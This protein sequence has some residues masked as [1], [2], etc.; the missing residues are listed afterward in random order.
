M[1]PNSRLIKATLTS[2]LGGLLYG[3]DVVVISGIIDSVTRLYRLSPTSVGLTVAASPVGNILG[4]FCAG[5]LGQR[6]G[7][8]AALCLAAAIYLCAL[9]AAACSINWPMLVA[10]RFVGGMAIGACSVLGPVYITELS[11]AQWRGRLVGLFQVNLVVGQCVCFISNYLVRSANLGALEWHVMLSVTAAPT[12]I[13][14]ILLFGIP[15]S[16]RWLVSR[17]RTDEALQVLALVGAPDPKTELADIQ[18][19]LQAEHATVHEP[20]FQW[21]YRY[22]LFLAIAIG[23]FNQLSGINAIVSYVHTIF[24]AAGFSQLSSDLQAIAIGVTNLTFT[25]VGMAM[26]DRFGRKSL[27]VVGAIGTAICLSGVAWVFYSYSHQSALLALLVSFMAFFALSQGLVVYVYIGE[28]FPNAVRARGQGVGNASLSALNT[29]VLFS[30]PIL[31][32]K[33]SQGAPFA[34]FAAATVVQLIVVS[35]FFPETKGQTLEQLQRKLM[36]A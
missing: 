13:F 30:F 20:V 19:A 15:H 21:K 12:L 1:R 4:C 6:L 29:T 28:I 22:P 3:F 11:P 14:L 27:L 25:L 24:T 32:A 8:R 31:A 9:L 2:A 7:R 16:P 35:L 5:V 10:A 18:A 26:I 23:A 33:F 34:F 36:R 17:G